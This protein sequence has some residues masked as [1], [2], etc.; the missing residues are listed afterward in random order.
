M[1]RTLPPLEKKAGECGHW[2]RTRH[3]WIAFSFIWWNLPV[4]AGGVD[5]CE[6]CPR[7]RVVSKDGKKVFGYYDSPQ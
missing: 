5:G 7:I 1:D 6:S 3:Y 4:G 2:A